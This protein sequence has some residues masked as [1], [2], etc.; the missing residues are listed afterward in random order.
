MYVTAQRVVAPLGDE[1]I[2]AFLHLH[3]RE[4]AWPDDPGPLASRNPGDLIERATE[5]APGGNRVL[6]Y[7]DV[8]APDGTERAAIARAF[9]E[10]SADLDGRANPTWYE[11]EGVTVRFGVDRAIE[12]QGLE[13]RV[14]QL[15]WLTASVER[16][17]ARLAP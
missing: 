1:G 12:A 7:L 2:N 4:F 14:A 13:A 8:L 5:V 9:A 17:M 3:G 6:A 11:R 16:L 10:L 15:G